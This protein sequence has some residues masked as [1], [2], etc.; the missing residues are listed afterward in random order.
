MTLSARTARR[1]RLV[2]SPALALVALLSVAAIAVAANPVKSA[3]YSGQVP[4]AGVPPTTLSIPVTFKV[5]RS[6]KRLTSFTVRM[7][8]LP[9]KCGYGENDLIS[10]GKADIKHGSFTLKLTETFPGGG[11]VVAT[12]TVTGRF[13]AGRSEAGTIKTTYPP[14]PGGRSCDGSFRYS[15]KA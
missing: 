11:P 9:N 4:H 5:S 7:T 1:V 2:V 12:A 8:N 3:K 15:T 13:L 14:Y 6:G 10:T